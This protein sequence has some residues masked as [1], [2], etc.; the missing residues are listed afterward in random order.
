MRASARNGS[1]D[2]PEPFAK[3][4]SGG[5]PESRAMACRTRGAPS[6]YERAEVSVVRHTPMEPSGTRVEETLTSFNTK[7][8]FLSVGRSTEPEDD[9][10]Y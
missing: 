1:P 5:H 4:S 7:S 3:N 2:G 6:R 8:D 9:D 10:D